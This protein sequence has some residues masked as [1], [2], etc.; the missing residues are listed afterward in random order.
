MIRVIKFWSEYRV[1]KDPVDW[2]LLAPRGEDF[3]RTQTPHRVNKINPENW[4][5]LKRSG[6]SFKD[7]EAKWSIIGPAYE[8][9]KRGE[10]LPEDGTPL[11]AWAGVTPEMAKALKDQDIRTVEDVREMG[12]GVMAKLRL[13]NA[14]NLPALAAKFLDG[15]SVAEKDAQI[16]EMEERM[17]AMEAL[18]EESMEK[19]KRGRPRKE[20]A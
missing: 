6:D 9:W 18:L 16:K 20:A 15:Q 12:D 3:E 19:P 17:K 13:P 10:E 4:P 1:G 14:R 5:E 7:A 8:A 2:V 11:E